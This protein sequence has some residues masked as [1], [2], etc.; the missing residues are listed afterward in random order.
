M[1]ILLVGN[2]EPSGQKSMQRFATLLDRGFRRAGH[3]TRLLRP[4][5]VLGKLPLPGTAG[6]WIGY[7]DKFMVFPGLLRKA[8]E[9]AD[10]V[11]ICDQGNAFYTKYVQRR[12]LLLTCHDMF[13]VRSAL[14]EIDCHR[15]SWTGR[16]LQS[17][18][19]HG[20]Q[21]AGRRGHIT[22]V[23]QATRKDILRVTGLP[24]DRVSQIYNGLNFPYSPMDIWQARGHIEK[25]GIHSGQRFLLHVGG[26]AWYKNR[27]GVLK[28]FATVKSH[29]EGKPLAMVMAGMPFTAAMRQFVRE[30]GISKSVLELVNPNNED[31]QALYSCADLMLFPSLEEG[32]GWPIIEAQACGCPVVTSNRIP[33]T[34]VGGKAAVYV[35]PENIEEAAGIIVRE[36]HSRIT[37]CELSLRNAA[38]F[39]SSEMITRYL[40]LHERLLKSSYSNGL[41]TRALT[42]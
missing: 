33:M 15:T 1:K 41:H 6:K 42:N 10:V 18:I 30:T 28:M 35:Q 20:L 13:A 34:E 23:S 12:P 27:I 24:D 19:L 11:Q 7:V 8:V 38:R 5:V 26:N 25:L 40:E 3:E 9:W 22:C 36:I 37:A 29:T 39:D 31:L 16:R 2:Y 14:G 17:M 32:F 21:T 4:P